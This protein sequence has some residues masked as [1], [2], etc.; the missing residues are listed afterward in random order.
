MKP[1]RLTRVPREAFPRNRLLKRHIQLQQAARGLCMKGFSRAVYHCGLKIPV[2][3]LVIIWRPRG[4]SWR[5]C[6]QAW[7]L[8]HLELVSGCRVSSCHHL[9][10]NTSGCLRPSYNFERRD[11]AILI[12]PFTNYS[13][14]ATLL[15]SFFRDSSKVSSSTSSIHS[16]SRSRYNCYRSHGPIHWCVISV[17]HRT[18]HIYILTVLLGV[19]RY[20]TI[21][22]ALIKGYFPVARL[23]T[24]FIAVIL[25]ALVTLTFSI[26][27]AGKLTPKA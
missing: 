27:I 13:S 11:Y 4:H 17:L 20:F 12:H 19:V 24:G 10:I 8:P 14:S 26:L 15:C 5:T 3:L 9:S 22:F 2:A 6:V 21:Q 23:A 18:A 1:S 16:T 7:L 25:T